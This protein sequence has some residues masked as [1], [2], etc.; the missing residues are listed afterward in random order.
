MAMAPASRAIGQY[1]FDAALEAETKTKSAPR[2][3]SGVVASTVISPSPKRIR[4]PAERSVASSL[5]DFSG[6]QVYDRQ[7]PIRC[8]THP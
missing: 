1:S 3:D 4:L 2:N 8:A 5:S 7:V 6:M